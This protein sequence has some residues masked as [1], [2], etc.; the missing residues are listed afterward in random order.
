MR[1]IEDTRALLATGPLC[2]ACLGRVFADRSFG[3]TNVERGKA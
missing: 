1:M 2:D 3:L